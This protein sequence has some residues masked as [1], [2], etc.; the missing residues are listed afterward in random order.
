MEKTVSCNLFKCPGFMPTYGPNILKL[1]SISSITKKNVQR[2]VTIVKK[3]IS[4]LLQANVFQ[5]FHNVLH[6]VCFYRHFTLFL[7]F[8]G[9]VALVRL[10]ILLGPVGPRDQETT[11]FPR[12]T[13]GVSCRRARIKFSSNQVRAS[14]SHG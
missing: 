9:P 14:T 3:N 12:H 2:I 13:Q 7:H 11:E 8:Y 1:K 5:K 4:I 10:S 6:N